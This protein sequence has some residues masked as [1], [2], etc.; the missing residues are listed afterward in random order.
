MKSEE[1]KMQM[2]EIYKSL[3]DAEDIFSSL[4]KGM[5]RVIAYYHNPEGT[6]NHCLRWGM[7]AVVDM[8]DDADAIVTDY[9][10]NHKDGLNL[11]M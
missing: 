3:R 1:F 8:L 11:K 5:Q 6:L 9:N 7:Q 4:P 10:E 2:A